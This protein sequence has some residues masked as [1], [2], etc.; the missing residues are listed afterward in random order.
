MDIRM[1]TMG[2]VECTKIVR[3]KFPEIKIIVLTTF[4]DDE[5]VF[6][7]LKYGASGYL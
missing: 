7:A 4:D 5:Y 3:E 2:G 6:S 1:P